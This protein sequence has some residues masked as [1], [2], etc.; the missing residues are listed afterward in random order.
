MTACTLSVE[1]WICWNF[2]E[3]R[4]QIGTKPRAIRKFA[5]HARIQHAYLPD[6]AGGWTHRWCWDP[7]MGTRPEAYAR[8]A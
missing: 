2:D 1:T 3:P 8:C 5:G 7:Y 6:G 4:I